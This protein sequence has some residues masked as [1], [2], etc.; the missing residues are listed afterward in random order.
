M[1]MLVE[2][3]WTDEAGIPRSG[4]GSFQ[5]RASAIRERVSANGSS[6]YKAEPGRYHL[7]VSY[8]CPWAHRTLIMRTL[9]K[10]E[11]AISVS[12]V[13]WH[14]TGEG[15][16]FSDRNGAAPDPI[17]G[18]KYLH[19]IYAASHA[20]Y[21]GRVTV[22]VLWEK[23]TA[24]IVNNEFSE[25]IRMLNGV[26]D[27]WGD[28]SLD[29]YPEDLRAEIDAINARVY[30]TLNNGIYRCGFAGTQ[31]AYERAFDD[32]F[33]TL[34]WMEEILS[35][36]RWLAG[37]RQTEADWRAFPTLVRFDAVYHGHFKCNRRR[38]ED[39]ENLSNYLRE[40][41]QTPGVAGSVN[42]HHIKWHYYH[43]HRSLNP[44]GIVPKGPALDYMRPHD[45]GR[46]GEGELREV[47]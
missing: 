12:V 41:F 4:D 27:E 22:P 9:K 38:I 39:Y 14:M 40:L 8:A 47:G 2:G 26:F 18:A 46:F 44:L 19:E 29:F 15:W 25:I 6:A 20:D 5:R 24:R 10:L 35:R 45:R 43:S 21:T 30:E 16:H 31:G 34:D 3:K 32:L 13:D 37:S 1:G 23:K 11:D 28:A 7:Y 42:M 17:M 33:A 36:R